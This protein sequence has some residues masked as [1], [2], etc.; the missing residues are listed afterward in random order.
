MKTKD[1]LKVI[2]LGIVTAA[3]TSCSDGKEKQQQDDKQKAKTEQVSNAQKIISELSSNGISVLKAGKE[4][5]PDSLLHS[6]ET[7][8]SNPKYEATD[9]VSKALGIEVSS[10]EITEMNLNKNDAEVVFGS[11]YGDIN[12]GDVFKFNGIRI[13]VLDEDAENKLKMRKVYN[14]RDLKQEN[15]NKSDAFDYSFNH[16]TDNNDKK[17]SGEWKVYNADDKKYSSVHERALYNDETIETSFGLE[18]SIGDN[19]LYIEV[20]GY[21]YDFDFGDLSKANIV[22]D[23]K[24]PKKTKAPKRRVGDAMMMKMRTLAEVKKYKR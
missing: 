18:G 12:T 17:S 24:L 7:D 14:Y 10:Y 20:K 8:G 22:R 15:R 19:R 23:T 6:V 2:G 11:V 21:K 13:K 16:E 9:D 3:I 5:E 4:G 1:A